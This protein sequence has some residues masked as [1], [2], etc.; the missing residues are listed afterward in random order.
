MACE[1]LELVSRIFWVLSILFA[2]DDAEKGSAHIPEEQRSFES[3]LCSQHLPT[4][5]LRAANIRMDAGEFPSRGSTVQQP[6]QPSSQARTGGSTWTHPP[7]LL[8]AIA[9]GAEAWS[10]WENT[11]L[12]KHTVG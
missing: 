6:W 9:A 1:G 4:L 7:L 3:Y 5:L 12:Y 8:P 11:V 2:L 10:M